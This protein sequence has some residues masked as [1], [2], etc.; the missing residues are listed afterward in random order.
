MILKFINRREELESLEKYRGNAILIYGRRRVG[1]TEL[2]KNFI[3][4]KN[5]FYFLCQ[6][7]KIRAEFERFLRKFNIRFSRYMEAKDFEEFFSQIKNEEIII[8][9]DEF[10]YWVEKNPEVT[11]LFQYILDEVINGSKVKIIFCGSLIGTMESLLSYKTPLYGRIKLKMKIEPLKFKFVR[12]F[13]PSYSFE[14][15]IKVY[16]CVGGI[17][18]YLQEFNPKISFYENLNNLFF[19]KYGFLYDDAE[20]MLKDELREPEIYLRIIEAI[21]IG[22]TT[23][24]KISSKAYVDITN[25]PKYLKILKKMGIIKK[26]K[27]VIGK[28]KIIGIDDN[29]FNFWIRFVYPNREEIE[30]GI[31]SFPHEKFN[32]YLG[33]IFEDICKEFLIETKIFDFTKIGKWWH[34]DK[35]IDIVALNERTKEILFAECKWQNKVNAEKVCKELLEKASYVEWHSDE[36]KEYLAVFAK[37]F[38]KKID[39]FEGR[40]VFCFDLNGMEKRLKRKI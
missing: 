40:K 12:Y 11:S 3:K 36:R 6:K 4:D 24:G 35:E 9:F 16:A 18:A 31:F 39:G 15:L 26:E 14:D 29:Y 17:P 25:L 27:S 13:L 21:A 22:E 8:V 34:K 2:I 1:K 7:N 20:R 23:F 5:A 30:L 28:N 37:S 19:N 33:F 10:S 32:A 38:S